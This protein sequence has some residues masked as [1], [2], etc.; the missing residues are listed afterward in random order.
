MRSKTGVVISNKMEKTIVVGVSYSKLH[1]LYKKA[2][3]EQNKFYAHDPEGKFQ[4]G[5]AVTIYECRPLS[6]TKR[7]T[8]IPPQK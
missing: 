1:P 6:K 5:D 3:T 8:V 2:Y 7:W 4:I